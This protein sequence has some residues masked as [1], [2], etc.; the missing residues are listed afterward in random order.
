MRDLAPGCGLFTGRGWDKSLGYRPYCQLHG[1]LRF[2]GQGLGIQSPKARPKPE[3]GP[4]CR[5]F[6]CSERRLRGVQ[7]TYL[8]E[9]GSPTSRV[10]PQDPLPGSDGV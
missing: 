2:R 8:S 6:R 4:M 5:G 7:P 10:G 1:S 3:P 9:E